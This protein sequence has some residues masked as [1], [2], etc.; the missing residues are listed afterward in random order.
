MKRPLTGLVLVYASGIWLGSM[1]AWPFAL[2]WVGV[3]VFLVAVFAFHRTRFAL[4]QLLAAVCIT[5]ILAYRLHTTNFSPNHIS[6]LLAL[7][8]QN[9]TLRG[10]IVSDTG[11]REQASTD[12]RHSFKL[13]LDAI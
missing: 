6:H 9:V 8:D 12:D 7:R 11:Y 4:A 10:L 1:F 5:G 3:A 2:L 13:Q